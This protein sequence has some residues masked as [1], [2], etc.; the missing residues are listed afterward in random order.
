MGGVGVYVGGIGD[1]GGDEVDDMPWQRRRGLRPEFRR[2]GGLGRDVGDGDGVTSVALLSMPDEREEYD[3]L[4]LSMLP[5][6]TRRELLNE[7]QGLVR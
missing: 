5:S 2:N 7:D 3:D 1:S 6:S 4:G